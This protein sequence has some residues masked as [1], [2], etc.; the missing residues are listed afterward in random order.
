MKNRRKMSLDR[1]LLMI[2]ILSIFEVIFFI[3][4]K[5]GVFQKSTLVLKRMSCT[6]TY[7]YSY[8]LDMIHS[9][10]L[11]YIMS[12]IF[13]IVA[14]I[15]ERKRQQS[16]N[17]Y[18]GI[19]L[20]NISQ[21][22]DD[23]IQISIEFINVGNKNLEES[24]NIISVLRK[25][26]E[27]FTFLSYREHFIKFYQSFTEEYQHVSCYIA[28]MDDELRDCLHEIIICDFYNRI[29]DLL[30]NA[31]DGEFDKIFQNNFSINVINEIAV[32]LKQLF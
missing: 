20:S 7:Q 13:Y 5:A 16:I 14:L 30:I 27:R 18:V 21:M 29:N 32:R 11:T 3:V 1:I 8:I 15:P 17:K 26:T 28:F 31:K 6:L 10:S 24:P 23:I 9:I 19:Y 12:Y 22:L 25:D 2:L 4:L